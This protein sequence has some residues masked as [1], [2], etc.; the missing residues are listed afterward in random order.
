MGACHTL[1]IQTE[2]KLWP[3]CTDALAS[4]ESSL[5]T[6]M[7]SV[8]GSNLLLQSDFY[9][10]IYWPVFLNGHLFNFKLIY[11]RNSNYKSEMR[12]DLPL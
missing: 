4:H 6:N 9:D 10:E 1:G 5:L 3:Y 11:N 7:Q 12:T 2:V 8:V